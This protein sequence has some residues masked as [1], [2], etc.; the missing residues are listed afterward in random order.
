MDRRDR[1]GFTLIELLIVIVILGILA[2]IA[3]PKFAKTRE[4]AY[5]AAVTTDMRNLLS[6]Q[7]FYITRNMT[8]AD[9]MDALN[10]DASRGVTV[11]ITQSG[12]NGWAAVGEHASLDGQ[13]AIFYGS[14]DA[15]APATVAGSVACEF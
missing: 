7:E 10:L 9:D 8:Y 13:C 14:A 15:E 3:I 2:A 1:H 12:S 6:A 11:T 4:R 5:K